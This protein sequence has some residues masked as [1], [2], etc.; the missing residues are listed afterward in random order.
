[1]SRFWG[2]AICNVGKKTGEKVKVVDRRRRMGKDEAWV[3]KEGLTVTH[4]GEGTLLYEVVFANWN[5]CKTFQADK[6]N[7][8]K[9]ME[10]LQR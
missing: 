4:R 3:S 5:E 1:M 6:G 10:L 9:R 8:K 7:T 2:T